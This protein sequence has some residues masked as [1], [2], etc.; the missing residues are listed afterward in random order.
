[1][2]ISLRSLDWFTSDCFAPTLFTCLT[3]GDGAL[4][5]PCPSSCSWRLALSRLCSL[6]NGS[7]RCSTTSG[8]KMDWLLP[9][10]NV[11]GEK[12]WF[13]VIDLRSVKQINKKRIQILTGADV[14]SECGVWPR[15]VQSQLRLSVEMLSLQVIRSVWRTGDSFPLEAGYFFT[16]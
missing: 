9:W 10:Q 15:R 16:S 13:S 14:V 12:R 8:K 4:R 5:L 3:R 6:M 1:M 7:S 2:D 11:F